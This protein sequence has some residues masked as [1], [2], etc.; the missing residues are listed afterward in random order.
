MNAFKYDVLLALHA[1]KHGCAL[2]IE[3][4]DARKIE[5]DIP[6]CARPQINA[7]FGLKVKRVLW[8]G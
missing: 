6:T 3:K 4:A 8:W 7:D 5:R 1:R 2:A